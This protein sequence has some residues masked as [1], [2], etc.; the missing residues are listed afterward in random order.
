M[1]YKDLLFNQKKSLAMAWLC[2]EDKNPNHEVKHA[3][4]DFVV[5]NF[6][7]EVKDYDLTIPVD[8]SAA[9]F[10]QRR[11]A[12]PMPHWHLFHVFNDDVDYM[13]NPFVL[14][15]S[16]EEAFDIARKNDPT[17]EFISYSIRNRG[18]IH[19]TELN[20]MTKVVTYHYWDDSRDI[21][22]TDTTNPIYT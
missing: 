21:W 15:H 18:F 13:E 7:D 16:V 10:F 4:A 2:L 5:E 9:Y 1:T 8:I 14:A 3:V 22:E 17:G 20:P 12:G 6:I 11:D 19:I